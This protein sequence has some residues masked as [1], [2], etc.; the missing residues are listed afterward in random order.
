MVSLLWYLKLN[1]LTRTQI[2]L[3]MGSAFWVW[4]RAYKGHFQLGF[5]GLRG[6]CRV[7]CER[8]VLHFRFKAS[9]GIQRLAF[10]GSE[11]QLL[12]RDLLHLPGNIPLNSSLN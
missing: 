8:F 1:P 10:E 2:T 6:V 7:A 3:S 9:Y 4:V 12:A 5:W 11:T